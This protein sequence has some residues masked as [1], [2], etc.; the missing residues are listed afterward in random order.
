MRTFA[1]MKKY[2]A[3]SADAA[4]PARQEMFAAQSMMIPKQFTGC[5][6]T[7]R[8]DFCVMHR[9]Y[10]QKLCTFLTENSFFVGRSSNHLFTAVSDSKFWTIRNKAKR[11]CFIERQC[12]HFLGRL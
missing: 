6:F 8:G 11:V 1:Y 3:L 4:A 7:E 9:A 2:G 10:G 12:S 5:T